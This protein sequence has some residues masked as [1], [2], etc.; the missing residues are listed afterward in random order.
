[1]RKKSIP[2]QCLKCHTYLLWDFPKELCWELYKQQG[3]M[4]IALYI[5]SGWGQ[6]QRTLATHSPTCCAAPWSLQARAASTH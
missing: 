1:M 2:T 3:V 5:P 6:L 4:F